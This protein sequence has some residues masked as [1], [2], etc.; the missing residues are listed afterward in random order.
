[1]GGPPLATAII[2]SA[3]ARGILLALVVIAVV[4]IVTTAVLMR[5]HRSTAAEMPEQTRSSHALPPSSRTATVVITGAIVLF[6]ATKATAMTFMAL[7]PKTATDGALWTLL[8]QH[9]RIGRS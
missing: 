8:P 9:T 6:Q 4:N 5:H 1:M 7:Y 3:G 2:G